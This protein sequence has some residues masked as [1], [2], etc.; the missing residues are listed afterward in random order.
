[1]GWNRAMLRKINTSPV[2]VD[3]PLFSVVIAARDEE[4]NIA[5]LLDDLS[6][7]RYNDFQVIIVDDHSGDMT[8]EI[9]QQ[10][11]E[12]DGRFH[13]LVADGKGKK[14]ALAQGVQAAE[15]VII[16][17]T[18]AD[19]RVPENWIGGLNNYF[20]DD[21]I[22]LVFGGVRMVGS[23]FFSKL[24][25]LEFLSLIG[26]GAA[27]AA[28][29]L[30][31]LCNGAN[32]AFRKSA[33]EAVDGYS[34]NLH[35]PSG[36]DEFLMRKIL[37]GYPKG[38]TFVADP[39]AV[40][41]TSPHR[42]L[43]DL[44]HQRI[45]WAGKWSLHTPLFYKALAL[46]TFCFQTTL[47]IFPALLLLNLINPAVALLLWLSKVGFELFFLRRVAGFLQVSWSWSAFLLLQVIYP[48]Y[49]VIIGIISN[50]SP[51]EWKGRKSKSLVT[52]SN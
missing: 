13:L 45:R 24:Q 30:P 34:G 6:K 26:S 8:R 35:I 11:V 22:K 46:S 43:M 1:M 27:T 23:S 10:F 48:I 28:L 7:Q 41:T 12:K 21:A 3:E 19:C 20:G 14:Q 44:I 37:N 42:K 52:S 17:T 40:V 51:F 32:M 36:D 38:V 15:G 47:I 31:T 25:S 4:S 2:F 49:V 33:F 50:F 29:G 9:V 39:L 5:H 16:A 18:D